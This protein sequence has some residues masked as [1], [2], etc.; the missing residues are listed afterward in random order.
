MQK[1]KGGKRKVKCEYEVFCGFY[2]P[3]SATKGENRK[4][5]RSS[6]G[7]KD[8]SSCKRNLLRVECLLQKHLSFKMND[9]GCT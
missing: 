2:D 5:E 6:E 1:A 8:L 3:D 7:R 9:L 4:S